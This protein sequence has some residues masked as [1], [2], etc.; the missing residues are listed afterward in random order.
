MMPCAFQYASQNNT[1][2]KLAIIEFLFQI[3]ILG[4]E[5]IRRCC[6]LFEC[7]KPSFL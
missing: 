6:N 1:K 3:L 7:R 4:L 5:T 2:K